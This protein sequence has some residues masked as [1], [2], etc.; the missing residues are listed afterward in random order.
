M[1]TTTRGELSSYQIDPN[2]KVILHFGTNQ[3]SQSLDALARGVDIASMGITVGISWPFQ[4]TFEDNKLLVSANIT[5]AY[6]EFIGWIRNNNWKSISPDSLVIG[7][8]NYNDHAFE[9][10]D[11]YYNPIFSVQIIGSNEIRIAGIFRNDNE[12]AIISNKGGGIWVNMSG[13]TRQE[14][15]QV[16]VP[17]FRYPSDK[18]PNQLFN[19][20]NDG[21]TNKLA[22]NAELESNIYT[23]L[24][25]VSFIIGGIMSIFG[26][27]YITI[28]IADSKTGKVKKGQNRC[29]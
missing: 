9:V 6:G 22:D 3:V 18:Y 10:V 20:A 23:I 11:E 15:E 2:K 16:L 19:S 25:Y 29:S 5:N 12:T 17:L 27:A 14:I 7:D 26:G 8:R 24:A 4:V 13:F 28:K 21:P 1:A